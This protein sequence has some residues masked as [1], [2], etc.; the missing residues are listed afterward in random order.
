MVFGDKLLCCGVYTFCLWLLSMNY[1]RKLIALVKPFVYLWWC[2][3]DL[4]DRN[5]VF[6]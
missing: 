3:G 5:L 1:F 4:S 2:F 6:H